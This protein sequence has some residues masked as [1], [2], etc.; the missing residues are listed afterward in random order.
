M[1]G[2]LAVLAIIAI[3]ALLI[4]LLPAPHA[5]LA[6]PPAPGDDVVTFVNDDNGCRFTIYGSPRGLEVV[7]SRHE[8]AVHITDAADPA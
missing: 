7:R 5:Q 1:R 3:D 4:A 2:L 6:P 8:C